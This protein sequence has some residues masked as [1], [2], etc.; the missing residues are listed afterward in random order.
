MKNKEKFSK[1][2]IDIAC[3]GGTIAVTKDN[4]VV[5][6]D[7][8][9]CEQCLFNIDNDECSCDNNDIERWAESEYVEKLAITSR[10]EKFLGSL[11]PKY[12]YIA[13]DNNDAL[14]VYYNKPMRDDKNE[15]WVSDNTDYIPES[16][17]GSIFHF[18]KWEDA[19]PWQI[20]DLKKLEVKDE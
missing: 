15:V 18:I 20:D 7:D 2:I 6:C 12:K 14:Y 13:R 5:N 3:K 9:T 17:F 19:E 10:E 1:E 16:I 4:K 8:I 11:L